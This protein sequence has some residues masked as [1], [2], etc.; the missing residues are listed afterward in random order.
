MYFEKPR[1][2]FFFSFITR[3]YLIDICF[4]DQLCFYSWQWSYL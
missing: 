2:Y 3:D 1:E 4:A